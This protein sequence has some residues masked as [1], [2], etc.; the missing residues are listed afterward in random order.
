MAWLCLRGQKPN[1]V[2]G[3]EWKKGE[4]AKGTF[5]ELSALTK[6]APNPVKVWGYTY[7]DKISVFSVSW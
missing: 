2:K 6:K 3:Y 7:S 1:S 4:M 5:Y